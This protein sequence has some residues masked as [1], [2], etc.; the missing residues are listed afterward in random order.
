MNDWYIDYITDLSTAAKIA[1][2]TC[3]KYTNEH[4]WTAVESEDYGVHTCDQCG[5]RTENMAV[6]EDYESLKKEV[7]QLRAVTNEKTTAN[8][9][10]IKV[11]QQLAQMREDVDFLVDGPERTY[12][13]QKIEKILLVA[14]S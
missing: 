9:T 14:C 5:W 10:L 6:P 8:K 2:R 13:M 4:Q 1:V 11:S 7:K 12:I 3:N